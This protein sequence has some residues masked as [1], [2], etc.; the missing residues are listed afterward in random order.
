MRLSLDTLTLCNYRYY[1]GQHDIHFSNDPR[2]NVT[3]IKGDNGAGKSN[4]LNA[5]T[6]CLYNEEVHADKKTVSLPSMNT[7]YIAELA[8]NNKTGEASVILTITVDGEMWEIKRTISG[9]GEKDPLWT[10]EEPKYRFHESFNGLKVT[11][12]SNG[13][14]KK[15]DGVV[16]QQLIN[17][18]LPSAL[19]SF[20]F[21]DG[22]QLREFFKVDASTNLQEA[23]E[24]LSQLELV[25]KTESSLE[26]YRKYLRNKLQE[27]NPATSRV[28]NEI[29]EKETLVRRLEDDKERLKKQSKEYQT[30]IDL[31]NDFLQNYN[32]GTISLVSKDIARLEKSIKEAQ[33]Q[34]VKELNSKNHYLVIRAPSILLMDTIDD[35]DK[36]IQQLIEVGD[37]PPKIKE[38]FIQE[39]LEK[40]TCVCGT[41]LTE[42]SRKTLKDY[43]EK[44]QISELTGIAFEGKEKFAR[45]KDLINEFP[46]KIDSFNQNLEEYEDEINK[47]NIE[48]QEKREE[49]LKYN[50][51]EINEKSRKSD[52][53]GHKI[54]EINLKLKAAN[55]RLDET[56]K[57]LKQLYI[58]EGDEIAKSKA[59]SEFTDKIEL[60]QDTLKVLK[61]VEERVKEKIRLSL[62]ENTKKYFLSFLREEGLFR[63][64]TIDH[65]YKVSVINNQGWNNLGDLS[66]GQYLIL[67]YAF[68]VALRTITGYQAPVIVDTPLG[69]LDPTHQDNI[70]KNL[71]MLLDKAQL[72]FLVTSSEYTPTVQRNFSPYM[73]VSSYY[74]I[75]KCQNITSARLSQNGN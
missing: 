47:W 32:I 27:N 6:W 65:D 20:F 25:K 57:E 55:R 8:L 34:Y 62:E 35:A 67:G 68:V 64:V 45:H 52:E 21:I 9:Y 28:Q 36:I 69:K 18:L 19:R 74:E 23:I 66:A 50:I 49:L 22:E 37:L 4:I 40:G 11:Y 70:T 48:L 33:E 5:L 51:D 1:Y 54:G 30:E 38:S 71:P 72:I 13:D 16:A 73:D 2:K 53:L 41:P 39:L 75:Q 14:Y 63:D 31:I 59:H 17:E 10:E 3:V 29:N 12:P 60:V 26:T 44:I 46:E 61:K 15:V 43:A 7:E 42:K 56:G 24:K 58:R